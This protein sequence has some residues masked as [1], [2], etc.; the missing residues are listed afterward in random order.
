MTKI[1]YLQKHFRQ[2]AYSGP[3]TFRLAFWSLD[4]E[5]SSLNPQTIKSSIFDFNSE[6]FD[7][8]DQYSNIG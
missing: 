1:A 3:W 6:S 2:T 4:F 5:I 8:Q 7:K